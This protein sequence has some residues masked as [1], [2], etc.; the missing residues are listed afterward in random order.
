MNT[1]KIWFEQ[2]IVSMWS[3]IRSIL[4]INKQICMHHTHQTGQLTV[5]QH[6]EVEIPLKSLP[7]RVEVKFKPKHEP[8]TCDHGHRHHHHHHKDHLKWEIRCRR[9]G[10]AYVLEIKW[11]VHDVRE[12]IWSVSY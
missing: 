3:G 2:L 4:G 12:I 5:A 9:R 1:I 6:G 7:H 11:K 8:P 10:R